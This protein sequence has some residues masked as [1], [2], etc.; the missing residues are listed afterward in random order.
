MK[1]YLKHSLTLIIIAVSVLG[2]YSCSDDDNDYADWA[3]IVTV[4]ELEDGKYDFTLDNG[5]K[6]WVGYPQNVSLK[7]KYDRAIIFYSLLDEVKEGYDQTIK[8]YRYYD[9]LT[10]GPIYIAPE[11]QHKQDSIGYDRV[12][13][14]SMWE[15]G[16]YLNVSFGYDAAGYEA[17]MINL[18]S[19]EEDLAVNDDVVKL[20]FRHNQKG[21]PAHYPAEGYVSFDLTPYVKE[22]RDKVEFEI[23]WKDFSGETKSKTIEYDLKKTDNKANARKVNNN[24]DTNLNIY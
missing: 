18:V 1:D 6:L 2:F 7:P 9:V 21:D 4:N 3:F 22:G 24:K 10:K 12:K 19:S 17:H 8:L 13:V 15:G 14:Y 23:S 16:G 20:E 5:E 11:D